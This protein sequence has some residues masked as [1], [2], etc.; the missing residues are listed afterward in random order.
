MN[1]GLRLSLAKAE[2]AN[3]QFYSALNEEYPMCLFDEGSDRIS[4]PW[5]SLIVGVTLKKPL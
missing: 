5:N 4:V 3:S 1:K 2:S